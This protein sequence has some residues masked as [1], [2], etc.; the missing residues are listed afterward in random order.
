MRQSFYYWYISYSHGHIFKYAPI[1]KNRSQV[2]H[3]CV[4]KQGLLWFRYWLVSELNRC[5]LFVN[6]AQGPDSIQRCHLTSNGNPVV[7]MRRSK[8]RLSPTM[9]FP[10]L[11]RFKKKIFQI[12]LNRVNHSVT[13]FFHGALLQSKIYRYKEH[14]Y[15]YTPINRNHA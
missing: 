15:I 5:C 7:E 10:I 3:I 11:I 1:L 12:Y 14:I 6:W 4:D 2:T 9:G 8:D 13:L